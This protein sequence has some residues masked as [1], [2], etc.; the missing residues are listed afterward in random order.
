MSPPAPIPLLILVSAPSGAGKTT[1]CDELLKADANFQ[2]AVTCTTRAPRNGER[3]GV[4]YHFLAPATFQQRVAAGEFL[5]HA[6]VHGN[7]YGTLQSEV[8]DR[9]RSGHDVLLNIDVQGAASVR[10]CAG[11]MP[12]LQRSLVT[13]FIV[14]PSLAELERR[15]RHRATDPEEVVQRRLAAARGEMAHWTE[16]DYLAVSDTVP[17]GLRR[18]QAIVEAERMRQ[19][20]VKPLEV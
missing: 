7:S 17:D 6:T 9:L 5:E 16:F 10:S 18:L 3:D 4:D 14:A 15:L 12:E 8:L 13:V 1:L 11:R 19:F 20:R 2:R